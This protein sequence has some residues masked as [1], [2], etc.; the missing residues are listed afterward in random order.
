[1]LPGSL[2]LSHVRALDLSFP[3]NALK[4]DTTLKVCI[5]ALLTFVMPCLQEIDLSNANVTESV[6]RYFAYECPVLEKVTWNKHFS[7]TNMSGKALKTCRHLKEIYM[8]DSVFTYDFG[9]SEVIHAPAEWRDYCIFC[10]CNAKLERV[11][12]KNAK[13]REPRIFSSPGPTETFP[14]IGLIK[15]VRNTPSLRW[16]RSDLSPENVAILRA[17]RPEV[18]FA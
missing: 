2:M 6:L 15:F 16:F 7:N 8:D 10:H 18:T 12:L 14:Q 17:E 13:C 3:P 11:S 1:M 4:K 5:P 9:E